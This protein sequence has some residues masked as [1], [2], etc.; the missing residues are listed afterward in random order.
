LT[1][2]VAAILHS[3]FLELLI[4]Q[5]KFGARLGIPQTTVSDYLRGARVIDVETLARLCEAL[6]LDMVRVIEFAVN[7][8]TEA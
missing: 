4:T 3:A 7:S 8:L 1:F 5:A 2:A 6:D